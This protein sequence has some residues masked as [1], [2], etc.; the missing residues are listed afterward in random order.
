MIVSKEQEELGEEIEQS[1]VKMFYTWEQEVTKEHID[2]LLSI[3]AERCWLKDAVVFPS[4]PH[5]NSKRDWWDYDREV[6]NAAQNDMYKAGWRPVIEI[7][8]EE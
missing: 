4:N 2:E 7:E 3:I 8:K 1:L 6:Y 5:P